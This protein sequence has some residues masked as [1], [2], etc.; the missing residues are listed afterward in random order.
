[1]HSHRNQIL[2]KYISKTFKL[3]SYTQGKMSLFYSLW[4][5]RNHNVSLS[6]KESI[7]VNWAPVMEISQSYGAHC[8]VFIL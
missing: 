8:R 3:L 6:Q 1:L 7:S 4:G 5:N 2:I